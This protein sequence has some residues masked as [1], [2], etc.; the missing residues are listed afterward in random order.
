MNGLESFSLSRQ[1][2]CEYYLQKIAEHT[3]PV[4]ESDERM[5]RIYQRILIRDRSL[6]YNLDLLKMID[7]LRKDSLVGIDLAGTSSNLPESPTAL[8]L[9]EFRTLLDE[10]QDTLNS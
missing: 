3:P 2:N 7:T 10:T 8:N 4:T 9:D 5:I 1:K 6:L